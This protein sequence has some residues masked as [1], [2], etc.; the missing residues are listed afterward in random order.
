LAGRHRR[1]RLI[2]FFAWLAVALFLA[3]RHVMWR[4]EVRAYSLALTGRSVVDMIET[5]HGEGHP[6]LWYLM[7][8][9]LHTLVPSPQ[10]LPV[11]AF[12]VGAAAAFLF[13]MRAPFR[14]PFIALVLF[15]RFFLYEYTIVARNY[16]ISMLLLFAIAAL[17]SR[18][19]DKGWVVGALL[20]LL[21]NTNVHSVI[22][23]ASILLFWAV[24]LATEGALG[25][26]R[27]TGAWLV[28]AALAA[29]GAI[30]CVLEVYPPFNDAAPRPP[31][32]LPVVLEALKAI[33]TIGVQFRDLLLNDILPEGLRRVISVI[34]V[35]LL[36]YGWILGFVRRP[37][38]LAAAMAGTLGLLFVFAF[39]Y[40]GYYRHEALVVPFLLT[41][42]WLVAEGRGGRWPGRLARLG[43]AV[44]PARVGTAACVGLLAFELVL[45][46]VMIERALV[47]MPESRSDEL[48]QLLRRPG[49]RDAVVI[50]DPDY[51][52][53][54]LPY[55]V[56]NPTY[57]VRERRY[58]RYF[59]MSR[60]A[61]RTVTPD[62]ILATAISLRQQTGRPIVIAMGDPVFRSGRPGER[63]RKA[64]GLFRQSAGDIARF[65]AATCP[66]ARFGHVS[67]G[68]E[69]Y[70]V[71]L[72]PP[73]RSGN[74][75]PPALP[76]GCRGREAPPGRT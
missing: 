38:A 35:P 64:Y 7:L 18:F 23:A 12:A 36:L 62:D 65:R 56:S 52:L 44:R 4:D 72:L 60:R 51:M 75:T 41:L 42:S 27:A 22:L 2:V 76:P 30:L 37:A 16:G 33:P 53:E 74:L 73:L 10:V 55:Y 58:G 54:A 57:F 43:D 9:G 17:Y 1:A 13:A 47:G 32:N 24:E 46:A 3:L 25:R 20:L 66:L 69:S 11:T 15:G 61:M 63:M 49:L 68:D 50:G 45:S 5:V 31:P 34:L 6:A 48:A 59:I 28:A 14:W 40:R 21:C 8:R 67:G 71:F 39:I 29:V 19:R 70:D 26:T